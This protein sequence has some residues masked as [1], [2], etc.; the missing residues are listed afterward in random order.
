MRVGVPDD[1]APAIVWLISNAAAF[2]NGHDLIVDGGISAGRP[3]A[4]SRAERARMA[5][6][7]ASGQR[8]EVSG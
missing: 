1:V 8:A 5:D 2:V 4:I 7:L 3:A 6:V